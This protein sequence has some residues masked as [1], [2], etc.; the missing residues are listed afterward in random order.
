MLVE[1]NA[2]SALRVADRGYVLVIGKKMYEGRACEMLDHK[3][4]G[5]LY[6]GK[7]EVTGT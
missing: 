2:K 7:K 5:K 1:Q 6:L 4:I 3:E